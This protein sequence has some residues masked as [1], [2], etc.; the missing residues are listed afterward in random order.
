M[1]KIVPVSSQRC[2]IFGSLAIFIGLITLCDSA[3]AQNPLSSLDGWV[4]SAPTTTSDHSDGKTDR[5]IPKGAFYCWVAEAPKCDIGIVYNPDGTYFGILY[6]TVL[7]YDVRTSPYHVVQKSNP[8][9]RTEISVSLWSFNRDGIVR[10]KR[11]STGTVKEVLFEFGPC[12]SQ[13]I[14][15]SAS[16]FE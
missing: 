2:L 15:L 7:G 5:A 10:F 14:S 9:N 12:P 8:A 13:I 1:K 6:S 11:Q 4:Y 16:D 3:F